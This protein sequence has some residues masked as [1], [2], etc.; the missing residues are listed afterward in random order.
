MGTTATVQSRT[1][2]A[3]YRRVSATAERRTSSELDWLPAWLACAH[4]FVHPAGLV[5]TESCTRLDRSDR[6]S[7]AAE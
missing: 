5:A 7:T 4:P 1:S 6:N 2:A 3:G